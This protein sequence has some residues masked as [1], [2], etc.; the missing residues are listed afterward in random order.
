MDLDKLK[1]GDILLFIPKSQGLLFRILDFGISFFTHSPYTHVAMVLKDPDFIDP[2]LKG[3]YMWE[4]SY[5]GTPDPQDGEIKLGVQITPIPEFLR[6]YKGD[7][8]VRKLLNGNQLITNNKL[9]SIHKEV[10]NK[11]YDIHPLDWI[12]AIN[13]YDKQPQ[14]TD[15]FWCSALVS[16]ILVRLGYLKDD[17]DWSIV[18]PCDLSNKSE[19]LKFQN[20]EYSKDICCYSNY[21]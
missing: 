4:S 14:K 9:K 11:P 1:T 7:I 13:R 15:R 20:C 21:I 16:Y 12:N 17:V 6:T 18:R 10:Y 8:Y 3:L 2:C 5:E 19:Y